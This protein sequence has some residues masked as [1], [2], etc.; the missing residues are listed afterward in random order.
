MNHPGFGTP[1]HS[2][3]YNVGRG[4]PSFHVAVSCVYLST[5]MLPSLIPA[6]SKSFREHTP[7]AY[8]DNQIVSLARYG[9]GAAQNIY[10]PS[11]APGLLQPEYY[12]PPD[13]VRAR[14]LLIHSQSDWIHSHR[15]CQTMSLLAVHLNCL[16]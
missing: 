2:Q 7:Y 15:R 5:L 16:M 8:Q 4:E 10:A 1:P 6:L 11:V 9:A 12:A 13:H 3:Y 14:S